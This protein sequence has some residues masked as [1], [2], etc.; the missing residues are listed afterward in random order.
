MANHIA[1][2]LVLLL[3]LMRPDIV[4]ASGGCGEQQMSAVQLNQILSN[5]T[6]ADYLLLDMRPRASFFAGTIA[7]A[8]NIGQLQ[9]ILADEAAH[10]D[11]ANKPVIIVT[12]NGM[13]DDNMKQWVAR[14]CSK[15]VTTWILQGGILAWREQ[16][17]T[18]E[19]PMDRLT[20]P[21]T[22]PFVIPR[23]LC[24]MNAPA[25]KYN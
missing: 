4:L 13:L 16:G 9:E 19:N 20:V 1:S 10:H 22:I 18:L 5:G 17:F 12:A 8:I 7:G 6:S 15:D 14:L 3:L 23:G 25:Q 11:V 21:G 24:E 2:F